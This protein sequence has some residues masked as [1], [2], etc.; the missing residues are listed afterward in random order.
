MAVIGFDETGQNGSIFT[1]TQVSK[2]QDSG[3]K[4]EEQINHKPVIKRIRTFQKRFL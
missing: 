2:C 3:S 4:L 1:M